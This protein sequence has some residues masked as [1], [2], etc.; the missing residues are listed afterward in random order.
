[1]WPARS[2]LPAALGTS[3]GWLGRTGLLTLSLAEQEAGAPPRPGLL[4]D[5][6]SSH[7]A[8][9]YLENIFRVLNFKEGEKR[10]NGEQAALS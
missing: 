2:L 7:G 5:L 3:E 6:D 9:P 1:M 8:Q 4:L 10:Y